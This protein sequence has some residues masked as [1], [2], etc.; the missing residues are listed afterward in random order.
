[1]GMW[2]YT[3]FK[4]TDVNPSL[5]P[6]AAEL[7]SPEMSVQSMQIQDRGSTNRLPPLPPEG[8]RRQALLLSSC[9]TLLLWCEGGLC[10]WTGCRPLPG[11]LFTERGPICDAVG[12][13]NGERGGRYMQRPHQICHNVTP[14]TPA[15][16]GR[17]VFPW[18]GTAGVATM[19][20]IFI[21]ILVLFLYILY[22]VPSAFSLNAS[23]GCLI[24]LTI[25]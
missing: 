9:R 20:F 25:N 18:E 21:P 3:S 4:S 5:V 22:A 17:D 14:I 12:P 11:R 13:S 2:K 16:G 24:C 6:V 23:A 19:L 7:V 10:W 15:R 1:M 8:E